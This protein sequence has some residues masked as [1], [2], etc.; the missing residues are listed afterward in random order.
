[1][2]PQNIEKDH[3]QL[4]TTKSLSCLNPEELLTQQTLWKLAMK[5]QKDG[6]LNTS[7]LVEVCAR[8]CEQEN[9]RRV[10]HARGIS[11]LRRK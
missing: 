4:S 1:M 9:R 7:R 8:E 11:R 3:R 2:K 5:P 10:E 6:I